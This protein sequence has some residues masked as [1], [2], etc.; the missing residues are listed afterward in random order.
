MSP[1]LKRLARQESK[2][3]DLSRRLITV[4]DPLSSASEAY[5]TL[6]TNLFYAVADVPPRVIMLT[7]HASAEGK[8]TT[9]ANL[10]VVLAQAEKSTL[11]VDCDLR[12]PVLHKIFGL[13][14]LK[15]V[16]NVLVGEC[17]LEEGMQDVPLQNNLKAL[18]VGPIPPNP[19][20]LLSSGRFA[21]FVD[22]ARQQFDYVLLDAPP[23]S[24]SQTPP[25]SPPRRTGPCSCWT[26][27]G[28]AKGTCDGPY[29][30]SR[31]SGP[32]SSARS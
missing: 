31:P 22:R 14:N 13:R 16:V 10:G 23:S 17:S 21:E 27:R 2:S 12:R 8:S 30:A 28:P 6:R 26:P 24:S 9:C 32:T 11:M 4:G 18:T 25:S 5:R 3:G 7:S 20:E 15:G 19:A 1:K 29:E